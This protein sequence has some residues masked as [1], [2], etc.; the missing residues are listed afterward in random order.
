MKLCKLLKFVYYYH[1]HK[2]IKYLFFGITSVYKSEVDTLFKLSSKSAITT[3]SKFK[4]PKVYLFSSLFIFFSLFGSFEFFIL[5]ISSSIFCFLILYFVIS[6]IV[7]QTYDVLKSPI[8]ATLWALGPYKGPVW[9][10]IPPEKGAIFL[11]KK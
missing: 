2:V 9:P 5:F 3:A 7:Y 4:P 6:S 10:F 11:L 1:Y 8:R